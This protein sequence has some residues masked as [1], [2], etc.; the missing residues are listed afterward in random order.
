MI[1]NDFFSILY[2]QSRFI[3]YIFVFLYKRYVCKETNPRPLYLSI[4]LHRAC[5]Y[6]V[7]CCEHVLEGRRVCHVEMYSYVIQIKSNNKLI[8]CAYKTLQL[9]QDMIKQ[10]ILNQL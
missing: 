1:L 7:K 9:V 5:I 8:Y 6:F 4:P 10:I 2:G 3:S